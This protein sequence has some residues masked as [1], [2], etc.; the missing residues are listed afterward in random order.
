MRRSTL[1][2]DQIRSII[3][4]GK[5]GRKFI[6]TPSSK[7]KDQIMTIARITAR[8]LLVLSAVQWS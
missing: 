2:R 6:H 8:V 4:E 5:E 3:E 1:N 7:K